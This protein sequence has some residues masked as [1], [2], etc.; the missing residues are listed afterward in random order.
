MKMAYLTGSQSEPGNGSGSDYIVHNGRSGK[1]RRYVRLVFPNDTEWVEKQ[2]ATQFKK[3]DA[4]N[5][6]Q[7]LLR[8]TGRLPNELIEYIHEEKRICIH[9][10]ELQPDNCGGDFHPLESDIC[11]VN[12]KLKITPRFICDKHRPK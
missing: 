11:V 8:K 3:A 4:L 5:H 2:S 1:D 10:S 9:F 12:E 6:A 7:T